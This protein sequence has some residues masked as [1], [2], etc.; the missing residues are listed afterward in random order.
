MNIN[1]NGYNEKVLTFEA[2]STVTSENQWVQL[3]GNG[4]V[5]SAEDNS[6]LVGVTVNVRG[7]YCGVMLSGVVTAKK[8]G[9]I[10][11]GYNKL[12]YTAD[13]IT[14]S[15]NGREHLVLAVDDENITFI[16]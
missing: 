15:T 13:G 4:V 10:T 1:F 3:S 8:S 14:V 12:A 16:L 5:K 2:D 7:G 6:A 9:D 11:T